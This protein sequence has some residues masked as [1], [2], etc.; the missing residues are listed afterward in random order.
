M[1]PEIP[2]TAEGDLRRSPFSHLLVYGVDRRLTGALFLTEPTGMTHVVRFAGGIAV[3]VRPGDD[4]A[5]L[6]EL[7]VA[8][9]VLTEDLLSGALAAKGLL[10]D[11]LLLAGRIDRQGLDEILDRQ[12][13]LR[14]IRLF[15][16]GPETTYRYYDGHCELVDWGGEAVSIEPL[17]VVWAG[18]K[19]HAEAS[20]KFDDA[21]QRLGNMPLAIHPAATLDRFGFDEQERAAVDVLVEK[22][23]PLAEL[24]TWDLVPVETLRRLVY[25]LAIT[26]QIDMGTGALPVGAEGVVRQPVVTPN[27]GL[28]LGRVQLRPAVHRLGAAA[29]DPAGDGERAPIVQPSRRRKTGKGSDTDPP[30]SSRPRIQP[31]VVAASQ[32]VAAMPARVRGGSGRRAGGPAVASA[33]PPVVGAVPRTAAAQPLSAVAAPA[34]G[35]VPASGGSPVDVMPVVDVL[36]APEPAAVA[37]GERSAS[38]ETEASAA[39]TDPTPDAEPYRPWSDSGDV[40]VGASAPSM[41]ETALTRLAER[42]LGGAFDACAK[43]LELEPRHPDYLALGVWIR[44]MMAGADVK[45]LALELDEVLQRHEAHVPARYYRGMLRRRLGD[46]AGALRDLGRVLELA[47]QHAD[48]ARELKHLK[49][50]QQHDPGL[51]ARLFKR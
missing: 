11:V 28:S 32:P 23:V 3:K 35:V 16:L 13:M 14:M 25:T 27:S 51:L 21:L 6:G 47:P 39:R 45:P 4:H 43:A 17:A 19:Q 9:G 26:R 7:L 1:V 37:V 29:P 15:S 49:S 22:P 18:L 10:G 44:S 5:R 42:D 30:P 8:A 34:S 41:F 40:D 38:A 31:H 50:R 12:F 36:P 33:P 20:A 2:P 46:D 48:A 24:S